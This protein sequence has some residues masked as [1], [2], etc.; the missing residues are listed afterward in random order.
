VKDIDKNWVGTINDVK[1]IA[2][3]CQPVLPISDLFGESWNLRQLQLL[4][5]A[6]EDRDPV[7]VERRD[8]LSELP[9]QTMNRRK[10][11]VSIS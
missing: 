6:E 11:W 5:V 10:Y 7:S 2:R 8:F 1:D 4:I 3:V 9:L